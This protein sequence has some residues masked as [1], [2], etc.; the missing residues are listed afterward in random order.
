MDDTY[1]F[2]TDLGYNFSSVVWTLDDL[3]D[4]LL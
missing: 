4:V 2:S 3:H 1:D